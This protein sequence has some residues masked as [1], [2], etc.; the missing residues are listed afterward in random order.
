MSDLLKSKFNKDNKYK[1]L[2]GILLSLVFTFMICVYAPFCLYAS[3]VNEF[4]FKFADIMK[5]LVGSFIIFFSISVTINMLFY[6]FM[7]KHY[8]KLL[9]LYLV[10]FV[11]SYIQGNI[12]AT[13]MSVLDGSSID[14]S[15]FTKQNVTTVVIWLI[16]SALS[17]FL[18]IK[19]KEKFYTVVVKISKFMLIVLLLSSIIT[20]LGIKDF[21]LTN[22]NKLTIDQSNLLEMSENENFVILVLDAV[23]SKYFNKVLEW[24][25]EYKEIFND[26]TYYTNMSGAYPCTQQSIPCMLTGEWFKNEESFDDYNIRAYNNSPLFKKLEDKNYSIDLYSYDAK[27]GDNLDRF[28]SLSSIRNIDYKVDYMDL[29]ALELKTTAYTYMPYFL[30][31]NYTYTANDFK[32]LMLENNSNITD[33]NASGNTELYKDG[34][35]A[36]YK[37]ISN[38]NIRIKDQN[39]FKFI[40]IEGAHAPYNYDENVNIVDG[41]TDYI[42]CIQASLTITEQYLNML[43]E[44]GVYDNTVIIVMADHGMEPN[45]EPNCNLRQNPIFLVK[46]RNESHSL[47]KNDAPVS[48]IDLQNAYSKLLDGSQS[49]ELFEIDENAN[50]IRP[51]ITYYYPDID[52]MYECEIDGHA[53][54]PNNCVQTGKVY[55]ASDKN[56]T[57][58]SLNDNFM[59]IFVNVFLWIYSLSNN[60]LITLFLF[61]IFIKLLL[62]PI[63]IYVQY[64]SISMVKMQPELNRIQAKYYGDKGMIAEKQAALYKKYK[65]NPIITVIPMI[66][67]LGLLLVVTNVLNLVLSNVRGA[68]DV[69]NVVCGISLKGTANLLLTHTSNLIWLLVP[70]IAGL[71]AY[72]MCYTQNKSNVIQSE[73]NNI[74]KYITLTL[75]VIISV[76]LG[77]FAIFG[78]VIYWVVGNLLSIVQMY[79]LN[80]L[81]NPKK[82]IDYKEL[83][84][85]KK[86]LEK[87]KNIGSDMD[88]AEIKANEFRERE[89][90]KR[91]FSIGNKHLVFYSENNGFYKYYKGLIDYLLEHTNLIIHYITSDPNDNI[92]NISKENDRIKSYYISENKLITLMMKIDAD[93]VVM[94][95]PDIDNYHIKRSYVRNDIEYIYIPHGM[96]S[97]NM[98]MR[99]HSMDNYDTVFCTG[100]HQKE[101]A[102][103]TEKLYKLHNRNLV[104][105]GYPLLDDMIKAYNETNHDEV[106]KT[107]MIAPSWQEDNIVDSCLDEIL[108][109]LKNTDY[110]IIVR[111]HPQHVRLR[112]DKIKMLQEKYKNN[113]NVIIQ[114]DFSSNSDVFN[115]SLLITDWS[116]IGFEYAYATKKPVMFINTPMKI[117]NP[118]YDKINVEPINITVRDKIGQSIDIDKLDTICE[119]VDYLINHSDM[120]KDIITEFVETYTYN[121]GT[122]SKVGATY[123]FNT[124]KEKIDKKNK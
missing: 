91:F 63:S 49:D 75:S 57:F 38:N 89:D 99:T 13:D 20:P 44:S 29:A 21:N 62:L 14:W 43:K 60:I 98:T 15:S 6:I 107:I 18:M 39:A 32:N 10:V 36:F 85:S 112:S 45:D 94:T 31:K 53:S 16:L 51:F 50:R 52:Y 77:F 103:E 56:K 19:L 90:Y 46:G 100:I 1:Y 58:N 67:Q 37:Y 61:T 123:I 30:K 42:Q 105:W 23:N 48:F 9:A 41:G 33:E 113:E 54:D 28:D 120:Y 71:S 121:L 26:F 8:P 2:S 64:S 101:E 66:L 35:K 7:E 83:E 109:K 3:N 40:H 102:L 79:L 110:K 76:Y 34:N 111:P 27:P 55:I 124:I 114:T 116:G 80:I 82:Y 81:I 72:L 68:V 122:S 24:K 115:A 117:M 5:V 78:L 59:Q 11:A 47:Q 12:L 17:L 69:V 74:N 86:E 97:L 119:K 106:D 93:V 65:Y 118:E 104:E 88:P 92:F 73:Q 25:P 96:D 4:V 84:D 95:M 87:L 22:K 108:D 70:T